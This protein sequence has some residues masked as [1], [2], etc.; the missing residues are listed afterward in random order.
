MSIK[1]KKN[2]FPYESFP[3]RLEL[4]ERT[5]WFE[6]QEHMDR[7]IARYKLR[8]KDY[9]KSCKRGHKIVSEKKKTVVKKTVVKKKQVSKKREDI[10][11]PSMKY[12]TIQFD[13]HTNILNPKHK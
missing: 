12:K 6:C 5:A 4:K 8:P 3:Y 2:L 1:P 11:S 7:E 9:K 13:K 10:L